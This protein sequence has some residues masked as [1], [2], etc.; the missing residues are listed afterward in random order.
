M[1]KK[2]YRLKQ[3]MSIAIA[4]LK[5][6]FVT[7]LVVKIFSNCDT[8]IIKYMD[9][10]T[11]NILDSLDFIKDNMATKGEL[12]E[13]RD[14]VKELQVDVRELRAENRAIIQKLDALSETVDGMKGYATEIDELRTRVN[15]LEVKLEKA[16]V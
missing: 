4:A 15:A 5:S 14:D 6:S 12:S 3:N 7:A 2:N 16:L 10:N 9:E 8:D 1:Y 11:K 13:L